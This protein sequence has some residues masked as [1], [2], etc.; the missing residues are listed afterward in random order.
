MTRIGSSIRA[1]AALAL[2]VTVGCG[3]GLPQRVP[4]SGQV[5]I[6]GVPLTQG[7][8]MV[9]PEG[10]RPAGGTI[11]PDGRFRLSSY[12]R[13]DGVVPGTHKVAIQ[14]TEHL[15]ERDTRWLAPKK[16]G[17][18]NASGLTITVTEPRDDVVIEI[19]WEGKKPFVERM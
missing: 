7:S 16:Y 4:V 2:L 3:D 18:P 15:S 13:N 1:A 5:L 17:N 11:G 10:D 12:A 19:T 6:D 9:V 8:I 14:A